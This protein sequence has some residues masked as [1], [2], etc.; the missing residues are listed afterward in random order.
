MRC[1]VLYGSQTGA[2]KSIAEG[3][4]REARERG[5][6]A[7]LAPL[8]DWAAA[9][10]DAAR[11]VVIVAS[12]TGDGDAPSNAEDFC[13]HLRKRTHPKTLLAG[14]RFAILGLG[15]TNYDKFWCGKALP[16][17]TRARARRRRFWATPCL[18]PRAPA[19]TR[20]R[21]CTSA[22]SSWA[23]ARS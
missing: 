9:G 7:S 11:H 21:R 16:G 13:R 20:P 18:L 14:K 19:A 1:L 5:H 23:A 17:R 4:H 3:L 15:D 2:A 8:N 6:D 10:L 22:C 12:T